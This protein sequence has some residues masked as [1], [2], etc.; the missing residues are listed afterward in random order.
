MFQ[1]YYEDLQGEEYSVKDDSA[2]YRVSPKL[3]SKEMPLPERDYQ[4][5]MIIS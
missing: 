5:Q 2:P 4:S 1:E 3:E